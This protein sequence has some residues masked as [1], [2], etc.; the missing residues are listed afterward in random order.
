M[1]LL[2]ASNLRLGIS[3]LLRAALAR[4]TG[5]V[6]VFVAHGFGRS[7]NWKSSI[8]YRT[9]PGILPCGLW[10]DVRK[11]PSLPTFALVTDVGNDL[12]YGAGAQQVVDWVGECLARLKQLEARIVVTELPIESI[13]ATTNV[14]FQIFRTIFFPPSRLTLESVYDLAQRTNEG[15]VELS[16][17]HGCERLQMPKQWYG[18][19]PIHI[20]RTFRCAAWQRVVDAWREPTAAKEKCVFPWKNRYLLNR[21]RPQERWLLGRHQTCSQP[22]IVLADGSSV[23]VY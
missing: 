13:L 3:D 8:P 15:V 17:R 16:N 12:L 22:S 7:Y 10:D 21:A 6:E 5:S 19:D 9:L 11:R 1:V 2:G 18:I 20:R 14:R 23:A 4:F